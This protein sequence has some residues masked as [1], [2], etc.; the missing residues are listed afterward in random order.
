VKYEKNP[1]KDF[2]YWIQDTCND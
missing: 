1:V 2:G